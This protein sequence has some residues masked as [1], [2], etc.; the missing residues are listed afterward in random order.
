MNEMRSV[1]PNT[2]IDAWIVAL[3]PFLRGA[4]PQPG[5][6]GVD[7]NGLSYHWEPGTGW[8]PDPLSGP[9]ICKQPP[10]QPH[11]EPEAGA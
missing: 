1:E 9:F 3:F 10:P 4:E 11:R 2:G 6:R 7:R 5:E 8:I